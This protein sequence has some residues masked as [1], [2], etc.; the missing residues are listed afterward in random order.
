MNKKQ[1]TTKKL[2]MKEV[3]LKLKKDYKD[4]LIKYVIEVRKSNLANHTI[5]QREYVATIFLFHLQS[6]NIFNIQNLSRENIIEFLETLK[7]YSK[8]TIKDYLSLLKFFLKF[9]YLNHFTKEAIYLTLPKVV[10]PKQSKIPS[11]WNPKDIEKLLNC[12]NRKT[13]IGKRDYAILLLI[14]KLGLRKIDVINLKFKDINWN[15]KTVNII[16]HKTN[17]PISLPILDDIGWAIIDYIKNG[18]PKSDINNIFL[19]H[20]ENFSSFSEDHGNFYAI[21]TKYMKKANI[22]ISKN[23]KNGVH[24]LR[25]T[26]ASE[27]LKQST[28]IHTISSVL[29]HVNSNATSIYLKIDIEKLRECTLEVPNNE[30]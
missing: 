29:G 28:P 15:N 16:Q 3:Q 4:I 26:L 5:H 24:S 7:H 13:S 11:S 22:P 8:F 20:K 14:I 10:V 17:E 12:I 1:S 9:L 19:T 27:M 18:R 6:N 21:I 2:N 30:K 23:K 25:H